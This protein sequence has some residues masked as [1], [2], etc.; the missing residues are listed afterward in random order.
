M[1][2]L[3]TILL[4]LTLCPQYIQGQGIFERLKKLWPSASE[5]SDVILKRDGSE[6]VGKVVKVSPSY[7]SYKLQDKS[8]TEEQVCANSDIYLIKFADRGNMFFTEYGEIFFGDDT[9]SIEDNAILLYL[10]KGEEIV[11]YNVSFDNQNFRYYHNKENTD[12]RT[13]PR[14]D[15]FVVKYPNR[16]NEVV[17]PFQG[18]DNNDMQPN[19]PV[20]ED[21]FVELKDAK[22]AVEYILRTYKNVNIRALVV[23]GNDSF[24]SYYR[25]EAPKG[26]LY[27][28]DRKNIKSLTAVKRSR[29]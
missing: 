28:M 6:V 24:V 5:S 27:R 13:I 21:K 1:R 14:Q 16:P 4:I 20:P 17:T 2:Q 26:P 23:Y 8:N 15:V 19:M 18:S 29:R 3:F 9:G 11:A 7:T 10:S 22:P 12:L 25:K